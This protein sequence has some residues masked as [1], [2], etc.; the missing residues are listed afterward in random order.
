METASKNRK[1]IDFRS[2]FR[3]RSVNYNARYL[4]D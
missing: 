3:R 1:Q 4:R 2:I